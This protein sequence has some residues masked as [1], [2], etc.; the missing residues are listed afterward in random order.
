MLPLILLIGGL[1]CIAAG[2]IIFI[3]TRHDKKSNAPGIQPNRKVHTEDPNI[4]PPTKETVRD[5]IRSLRYGDK[6]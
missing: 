6:K 5:F 1:L 4:P 3:S 2:V